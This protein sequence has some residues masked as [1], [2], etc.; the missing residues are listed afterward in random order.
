[1]DSLNNAVI[2][3]PTCHKKFHYAKDEIIEKMMKK[4]KEEQMKN[5]KK[6]R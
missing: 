6:Y 1:V 2:V 3:C 4:L 5:V